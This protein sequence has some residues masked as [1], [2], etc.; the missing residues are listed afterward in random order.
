MSEDSLE[1]DK[2]ESCLSKITVEPVIFCYA[3]G[4]IL[5]VPVIQQY[6]HKRISEEKGIIYNTTASLSN[7]D[8]TQV[9]RNVETSKLQ[10]AVQS[11]SSFMQLGMVFSASAP[12]LFVALFLGAWS[13]RAGRRRVMG[14]PIFGSAVES[15][16]ILWVISFNLPIHMLLLAGFINGICGFF[17]T[18]V[19]SLFSYIADITDQ[20]QRAFRLGILEA[21]A[22]ISG[23][24]S[25]LSSG[26]LINKTGYK[27]PYMMILC[28]HTFALFY[29]LLKLPES[30]AKHL[31]E[32]SNVKVFSLQHMRVIICIFTDP[33]SGQR[34]KM[35]L[36]MLTS[37]LMIVSSIGFGSVI[38]LYAIDRP[39]CCNSILIGYYLA[40]SFFVQAVGAVLGL[41]FLRLVLSEDAVM[42]AGMISIICSLI[43]MAFVETKTQFFMVPLVACLGGVPTP[44]I[45]A[46][47]S[48][49][50]D[51]DEQ[52]AL[53]AAVATLETLCTLCGAALFNS[54][55]PLFLRVGFN[56]F[57]FLVMAVL[58]LAAL[59]ITEI[60]RRKELRNSSTKYDTE[61]KAED[62]LK[63]IDSSQTKMNSIDT[64]MDCR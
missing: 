49:L 60:Y 17:P 20:S 8:L 31:M 45:R 32:N 43:M 21:T 22:F 23:M 6:I 47:M 59:T 52:G 10:K 53:F 5:H 4:I 28:L 63:K 48:K 24:L 33:R 18:M 62:M 9:S 34:W 13:D 26:W 14:L 44:I 2:A 46:K 51:A 25:H 38:V 3:F 29:V 27:A 64:E 42:Q 50:V 11:E 61:P 37:G 1:E 30:R 58:M 54:I 39:L 57:S 36:L 15:A 19:L 40:T 56:G 41:R 55:Y 35:C 12:S 16:I 7:C